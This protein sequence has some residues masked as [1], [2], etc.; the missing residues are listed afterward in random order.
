MKKNI[1]LI[2]LGIVTVVC[3]IIGSIKHV[4]GGFKRMEDVGLVS[5]EDGRYHFHL[6]EDDYNYDYD[7]DY[8]SDKS[9]KFSINEK[10]EAFSSIKMNVHV[11]EI[12][13][14]EGPEFKLESSYNKDYLKPDFS[15][16]NGVLKIGQAERRSKFFNGGNQSCRVIITI[17]SSASLSSL[18]IDSNVGE[19]KLRDIKAEKI[20]LDVNVGEV[21]V[22][23]VSFDEITCDTNVGE[24][25]IDPED[26]LEDYSISLS[27]DVGTV[28]V[29]GR[30]YK[31]SYNCRGDGKKS[32]TAS[33]NVGEINVR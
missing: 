1:L 10:L 23:N 6:F 16:N 29:D 2:V 32:I 7:V 18:D 8:D 27:A 33:S 9:G 12:I 14:E 21:S 28:H 13:V 31:R 11:M 3:I 19:I 22:R 17:P 24:I 5:K 15:V 25:N 30:N 26:K 4:G 20:D